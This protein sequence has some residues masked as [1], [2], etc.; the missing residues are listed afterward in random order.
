MTTGISRHPSRNAGRMPGIRVKFKSRIDDEI[1]RN[2]V[3]TFPAS[4]PPSWIG[5]AR[6]GV[7]HRKDISTRSK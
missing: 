2:L 4:D 6:V 7:P 5:L 3:D 1:A